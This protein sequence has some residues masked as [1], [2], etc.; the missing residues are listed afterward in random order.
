MATA[1]SRH[2]LDAGCVGQRCRYDHRLDDWYWTI[3]FHAGQP[4]GLGWADP[5]LS[6]DDNYRST[7]G[8]WLKSNGS[9][10]MEC[11]WST[12]ALCPF[13]RRS[14]FVRCIRGNGSV[15]NCQ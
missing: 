15:W 5:G 4:H 8:T 3:W 9:E 12:G 13:N 10:E 6:V 14:L 7:T 1:D 11:G 2:D